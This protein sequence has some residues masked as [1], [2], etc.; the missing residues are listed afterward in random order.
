MKS[1]PLPNTLAEILDAC[2]DPAS[3][4]FEYAWREFLKRYKMLIYNNVIKRCKDWN[5]PRLRLQFNEVVDDVF[6]EVLIILCKN[7]YHALRSFKARDN[8]RA[9]VYYLITT[10]HRAVGRYVQ[11]HYLDSLVE[12]E[13]EDVSSFSEHIKYL[14]LDTRWQLYETI[15]QQLRDAA[16]RS[17]A[18]LERDIHIFHLYIFSDFDHHM[19]TSLPCLKT[20]GHR[21]IDNVVNRVRSI[22]KENLEQS[23]LM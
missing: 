23:A 3:P 17:R 16:K 19:I 14:N 20:I 22:I 1:A 15:V 12:C 9:F 8:E 11:K 13:F 4:H 18:N 5:V 10:T 2:S 6:G 21:V 7:N